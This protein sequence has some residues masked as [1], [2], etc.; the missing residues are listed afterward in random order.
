MSEHKSGIR[1]YY[2]SNRSVEPVEIKEEYKI[3]IRQTQATT[4]TAQN[5]KHFCGDSDNLWRSISAVVTV[6]SAIYSSRSRSV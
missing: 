6:S 1:V 5:G 2:N 4:A 3:T